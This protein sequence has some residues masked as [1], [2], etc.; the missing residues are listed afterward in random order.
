MSDDNPS[1][2]SD[3]LSGDDAS[4]PVL[5]KTVDEPAK[6]PVPVVALAKQSRKWCLRWHLAWRAVWPCC[7]GTCFFSLAF[8][9]AAGPLLKEKGQ[10]LLR[11]GLA[12]VSIGD[13]EDAEEHTESR[14]VAASAPQ[15]AGKKLSHLSESEDAEESR[16]D[17]RGAVADVDNSEADEYSYIGGGGG[18]SRS[19]SATR[20]PGPRP[21]VARRSKPVTPRSEMDD[22]DE[23]MSEEVSVS[24]SLAERERKLKPN[25][26]YEESTDA[27]S[28]SESE[29]PMKEEGKA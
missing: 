9:F 13:S 5:P 4:A 11:R 6:A 7:E 3:L 25:K 22:R 21:F 1:E 27:E 10:R 8:L 28:A 16:I 12:S 14:R 20:A 17:Q 23:G 18:W 24:E 2:R 29:L 26:S 19:E 15:S